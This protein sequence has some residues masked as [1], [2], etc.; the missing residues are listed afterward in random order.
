MFWYHVTYIYIFLHI[1]LYASSV[2]CGNEGVYIHIYISFVGK[3]VASIN[4]LRVYQVNIPR[5]KHASKIKF[6]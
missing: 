5:E 6:D 2:I 4:M 3:A 1:L